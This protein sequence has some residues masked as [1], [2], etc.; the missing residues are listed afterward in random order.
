MSLLGGTSYRGHWVLLCDYFIIFVRHWFISVIISVDFIYLFFLV[1][2]LTLKNVQLCGGF[3]SDRLDI[4]LM[5]FLTSNLTWTEGTNAPENFL[6][7]SVK[8]Y[9][10]RLFS[11]FQ[12]RRLWFYFRN[13]H[14][15]AGAWRS[16]ASRGLHGSQG[17]DCFGGVLQVPRESIAADPA[18]HL[19][20]KTEWRRGPCSQRQCFFVGG[21]IWSH[22]LKTDHF[23]RVHPFWSAFGFCFELCNISARNV[24][25]PLTV[26]IL[27]IRLKNLAF[28]YCIYASVL[29]FSKLIY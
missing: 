6:S 22:F 24:S 2:A 28:L 27:I 1:L 7:N 23:L 17:L 3:L 13:T 21:S 25:F 14:A 16:E 18:T 26:N 15:Q 20:C 8:Q 19:G 10:D 11:L 12:P 4:R 5:L 9:S 29:G